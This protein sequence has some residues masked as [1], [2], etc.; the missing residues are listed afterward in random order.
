MDEPESKPVNLEMLL[1][2][3]TAGLLHAPPDYAS[4]RK[5]LRGLWRR[6]LVANAAVRDRAY[7]EALFRSHFPR[8]D[9]IDAREDH[10]P[11][12]LGNAD[13]IILLYPD[14]IGMDFGSIERAIASRWP[15]KAVLVLNGRRRFFRLDQA[16]RRR[17]AVRR[18]L[19]SF[20][21]PEI[22]FFAAFVAITPVLLLV[23]LFRGHR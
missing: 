20:R 9:I 13:N 8:G 21:L 18:F 23:D 5:G 22:A 1:G 12:V 16:T 14:P 4:P 17:L 10:L 11:D 2:G 19:A 7:L 3:R 15:S 6:H